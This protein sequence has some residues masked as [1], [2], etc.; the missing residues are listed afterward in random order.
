MIIMSLLEQ[1]SEKTV[2]NVF[3]YKK[4]LKNKTG[5]ANC[6]LS[7][8]CALS[9]ASIIVLIRKEGHS[10]IVWLKLN[11][12]TFGLCTI[13]DI[14]THDGEDPSPKMLRQAR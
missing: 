8:S 11:N 1:I 5:K 2:W 6:M 14:S 4:N 9:P 10:K 13:N 3:C 7:K 12:I